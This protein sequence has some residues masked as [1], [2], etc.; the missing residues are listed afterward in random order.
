MRCPRCESDRLSVVDSRGEVGAIRRRRECQACKQRFTTFER[1]ERSLPFVIKKDDRREAFD[2]EKLR[3]G[4]LRAC[5]KRPISVEQIE[6]VASRI[7]RKV[8]ELCVKELPSLQIGDFVMEELKALDHIAYIR[9]ASVYKEFS[10]IQQFV[11]T[12]KTLDLDPDQV[13]TASEKVSRPQLRK[14]ESSG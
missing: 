8:H 5:E 10:D 2:L 7:E 14:V 3:G 13:Q 9:F 4:L 11:E 1:I 12:L 6:Q